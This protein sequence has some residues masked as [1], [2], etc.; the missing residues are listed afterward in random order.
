MVSP[1][2]SPSRRRLAAALLVGSGVA[3][4]SAGCAIELAAVAPSPSPSYVSDFE[5]PAPTEFAPLRGTSVEPGSL[6]GASLSAKIDN[7]PDARPQVGLDTADVVFEELVEGGMTRYVGVWHS[8]MPEVLGPVRS[9]RPMDPDIVSPFG[10]IIAYSGGQERF[11][12]LMQQTG[13]HNAIHGQPDTASTFYRTDDKRAPHNVLVKAREVASEHT[14][15]APPAQQFAFARDAASATATRHG[16]PTASLSYAFSPQVSGS[17][18]WD[19]AAETF[20]RA[21]SGAPDVDAAGDQLEATN[22]VVLR[23]AVTIDQD[24]PKTELVGSG[25]A[26]VSSGGATVHGT[27]SKPDA[28]SP[29]RLVDDHGAVVRL[30]PGTTWFELVPTE[31]SVEFTPPAG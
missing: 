14:D 24:I 11:V 26:W 9:I 5:A 15:L 16:E 31:G 30:A 10:G 17:W 22:V 27:W 23:V 29:V 2:R 13:V 7:H 12:A 28:T 21:Q 18:T 8:D 1:R 6:E 4:V 3:F 20:A 25:E 19:A